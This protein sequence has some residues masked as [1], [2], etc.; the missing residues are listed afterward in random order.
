MGRY[1]D[2]AYKLVY[3]YINSIVASNTHLT[4]CSYNDM[5]A[6]LQDS[7]C[8]QVSGM[9]AMKK[10]KLNDGKPVA[11]SV[12]VTLL[13][14]CKNSADGVFDGQAM[15][16]E[17]LDVF[18][19]TRNKIVYFKD[20]NIVNNEDYTEYISVSQIDALTEVV[21]LGKNKHDIPRYSIKLRLNFIKG[22]K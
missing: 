12:I 19:G 2:S 10:R 8:I 22:G 15:L 3:K 4:S 1:K 16:E 20:S 7:M 17:L 21:D 13:Y 6:K 5:D 11:R 18:Y 14:N 9:Q